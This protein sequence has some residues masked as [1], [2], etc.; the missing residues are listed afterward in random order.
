MA[1]NFG[2]TD[3]QNA[4]IY[5]PYTH[6]AFLGGI[7]TGKS[8]TGTH[9]IIQH[10]LWDHPDLSGFIGANTYDQLSQA[11]LKEFFYWL[12]YHEFKYVSGRRPPLDWGKQRTFKS[13]NNIVSVKTDY[14]VTPIYTRVLG[15]EN[16]LRGNEFSVYWIDETRDTPRETHDVI[17][18]RLRESEFRKGIITT[19]PNG[20]DWTW[21]R[22]IRDSDG[23]TTGHMHIPTYES[24][25]A[26]IIT[27]Q[28]YSDLEKMYTKQMADQELRAMHV[29]ISKFPAYLNYTSDNELDSNP[30]AQA[31]ETM[32]PHLP[33]V[34]AMDFNLSPMS[35]AL[36]QQHV[37]DFYFF[38]EIW[39]LNS[40]TQE[41][42][43]LL[44]EKVKNHAPG[45]VL[46][47]DATSKAGQRAAAGK[48]DYDILCEIL[49][50]HAIKWV[51]RTPDSNP[52]I[53]D[54]VNNVN[55]KLRDSSA[56]IHLWHHSRCTNIK[57]DL[58]RVSW[59]EGNTSVLDQTT[60]G[61]L[62]HISDGIGYAISA[63][64]PIRAIERPGRMRVIRR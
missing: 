23:L 20:E 37:D 19:T 43:N 51:N 17:L 3:W 47:G 9:F 25:K 45:I 26:G 28:F 6:F 13:Y 2:V 40:H 18:S 52:T 38:D 53:R 24:V 59:K 16:P 63:L 34:V 1:P 57:R 54:R 32:C 8:F 30:F 55:L 46:A 4:A 27:E 31:G 15:D 12:D 22:F 58:V 7:A 10:L 39:L 14:G 62:T 42:A 49:D 41:A 61:T 11:T 29:N 56:K 44:V 21:E 64:S 33:I 60:D 36:G 5:N 35:W 50:R 48:S